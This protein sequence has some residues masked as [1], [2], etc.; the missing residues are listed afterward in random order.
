MQTK[1]TFGKDV[2]HWYFLDEPLA[3][4]KAY[5]EYAK[6]LLEIIPFGFLLL[7][8]LSPWKNL[9]DRRQERGFNL[10]RAIES[11]CFSLLSRGVGST[12]RLITIA[13]G[14]FFHIIL[15]ACS[16]LYL[17]L[18]ISFPLW[19]VVILHATFVALS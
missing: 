5:V 3:I 8:F 4:V 17:G 12:V 9:H 13:L 16:L 15:L 11:A 18:W 14:L 7:T 6:A 10:N 2:L 1:T 19:T